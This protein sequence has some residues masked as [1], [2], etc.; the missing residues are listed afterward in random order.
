ML[1]G[2]GTFQT[3]VG[4]EGPLAVEG[5]YETVRT[6]MSPDWRVA[7]PY[8]Y[9]V[10]NQ[11]G[12]LDQD[13]HPDP[14]VHGVEDDAWFIGSIEP[15]HHAVEDIGHQVLSRR[16]WPLDRALGD[17]DGDGADDAVYRAYRG[18]YPMPLVLLSGDPP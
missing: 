10:L 1:P 14:M 11:P 17:V 3:L 8:R 5:T 18:T 12:D 2:S 7:V 15:G 6:T 13:G 9:D 4:F 16:V